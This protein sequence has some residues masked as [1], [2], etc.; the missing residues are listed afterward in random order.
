MTNLTIH[1]QDEIAEE[2]ASALR[3]HR[4]DIKEKWTLNPYAKGTDEYDIWLGGYEAE[5]ERLGS[6][7]RDW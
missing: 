1:Q 7:G 6:E 3:S 2:G 4:P 5:A